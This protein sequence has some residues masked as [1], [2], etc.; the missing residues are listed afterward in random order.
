MKDNDLILADKT[1]ATLFTPDP[2]EYDRQ[3]NLYIDGNRLETTKH[4]TILGL[5]FDPKLTFNE[6]LKRTENKAKSALKLVKAISGTNWGQQKETIVSTYKSYT[7]PILE[8]ACPAWAPIVSSTSLSKLQ[9]VQNSALR[10][11][12]GHTR[13]TNNNNYH[14]ETKV[15]P[16]HKHVQM[17]TS[18]YREGVR[19]QEH[20]LHE[21][22]THPE[23]DRKMKATAQ[24]LDYSWVV[25]SCDNEDPSKERQRNKQ[26]LH[27]AFVQQHLA[28]AATNDLIGRP[29][30]E[31]H[32]SEEQ[33]PRAMRRTL[34]QLRARKCPLLQAYLHSIRAAEVPS[35]PLCGHLEHDT[36]HLFSC[37]ELPTQ[38][39][40]LDLWLRPAQAAALV[41]EWQSKL[42]ENE[43]A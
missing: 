18:M 40:P 7:R 22:L 23:P 31:V 1:Q 32:C 6:H 28:D 42:A 19:D 38:L 36:A 12:T 41:E 8:Y 14:S 34:A 10:C 30:P 2:H 3:L 25:H 4:P 24:S 33:L 27:T 35:C 5:T 20:P 13:D 17:L 43:E 26:R 16:I 21:S 9:T 39:V 29:P 37:S 11:A 15:L